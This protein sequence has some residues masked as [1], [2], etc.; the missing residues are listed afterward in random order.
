[1]SKYSRGDALSVDS[2]EDNS[3]LSLEAIK[4]NLT[5]DEVPEGSSEEEEEG[6]VGMSK[7][8]CSLCLSSSARLTSG[9]E[10]REG[11]KLQACF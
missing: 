3:Q 7:S 6:T 5:E 8:L 2:T 4:Q 10:G 11:I 1:M 9:L